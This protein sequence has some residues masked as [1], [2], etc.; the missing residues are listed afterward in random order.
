MYQMGI[1]EGTKFLRM[2]VKFKAN[3]ILMNHLATII[4]SYP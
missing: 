2:R 3:M 1:G 4:Q